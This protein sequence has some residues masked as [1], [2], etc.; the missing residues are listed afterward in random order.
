MPMGVPIAVPISD[1]IRLPTMAFNSPPSEP[2]AAV[3]WVKTL[4]DMA[5]KPR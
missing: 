5:S 1:W 4:S 2:G 3:T